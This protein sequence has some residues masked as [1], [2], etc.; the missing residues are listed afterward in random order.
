MFATFRRTLSCLL[1]VGAM[2]AAAP[3][4]TK[5]QSARNVAYLEL[6]GNGL[7]Y[8][9]NY[10][11]NFSPSVSGRLGLMQFSVSSASSSGSGSASLSLVPLMVNYFVGSSHRLELGAGPLIMRA[12]AEASAGSFEASESGVGFGGTATIGYRYQQLDG[13]FM[14]RLG[15]TPVFSSSGFSPWAGLSLGYAF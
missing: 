13:G 12:S 3:A 8:T 15:L 14:F 7:L 5:A 1:L 4:S 11:R 10:E 6:G 9:L 2:L